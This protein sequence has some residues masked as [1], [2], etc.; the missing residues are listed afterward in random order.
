MKR[1][2]K[3]YF[4]FLCSCRAD[5]R[6][7]ST[8]GWDCKLVKPNF[9][10]TLFTHSVTTSCTSSSE[11]NFLLQSAIF[12][13]LKDN[14]SGQMNVAIFLY[15]GVSLLPQ[16]ISRHTDWSSCP[17]HQSFAVQ[18]TH[19]L[20]VLPMVSIFYSSS[21]DKLTDCPALSSLNIL[22]HPFLNWQHHFLTAWTDITSELYTAIW[23]LRISLG[24]TF[25][26]TKM[27]ISGLSYWSNKQ[28][29]INCWQ[30]RSGK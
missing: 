8:E 15:R 30:Y 23:H 3:K 13:C 14:M 7:Y 9:T 29:A 19:W 12:S 6:T 22:I 4:N 10:P 17:W 11:W 27:C 28:V 1:K 16:F 24:P 26:S 21:V 25:L 20:I 2:R 18:S 5:L